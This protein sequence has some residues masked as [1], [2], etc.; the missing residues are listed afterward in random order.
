[1]GLLYRVYLVVVVVLAISL[2][3]AA[4]L[5]KCCLPQCLKLPGGPLKLITP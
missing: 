5:A 1:M 2:R 3:G 4:Q